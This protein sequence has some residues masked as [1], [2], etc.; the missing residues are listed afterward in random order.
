MSTA[1]DQVVE[2]NILLSAAAV[3]QASFSI[4]LIIGPTVVSPIIQAFTS[5]AGMLTA[6]YDIGDPEYIYAQEMFEQGLNPLEFYVG[7]RT[8]AVAQ[9]DTF[10]VATLTTGH[11]YQFTLNGLVI[12]YT[13]TSE[14]TQQSV[15]TALLADIGTVYPT[16]PPVTGVVSGS[17]GTA[18][19]TLTSVIAGQT[20]S[21][22]AI[23]ASLTH[24][25]LTASNGIANDLAALIAVNN[26]WYGIVLCSN[27]DNDIEQLAAAVEPLTKIFIGTS[28]DGS[29]ATS[30][31][32]D[33]LSVLK[34]KSYKRTALIYSPASFNLG[35]DAGWMGGNLPAVPGSNN[36]AY[37]TVAGISADTIS[38]SAASN[39]IGDPVAQIA[40]KNGNI[41]QTVGG[42]NVMQMGQMVGGQYIDITI[43]LDWL[44]STIQNNIYAALVAA[45]NASSKVPYTDL[46]STA[47]QSQVKAAIDQGVTNGLIDGNS[48]ITISAPLVAS[49]SAL[50]RQNR[51]APTITFSCRLQGAF[52]AVIVNGTVTV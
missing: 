12:S 7:M 18:L 16:N 48:P 47:M 11:N 25:A 41:F 37:Y 50:Q 27:S 10:A 45:S 33:I 5:P 22:S 1:L 32:T 51:V 30:S 28:Q 14:D 42:V 39:I 38:S 9:V 21:Y 19:L 43:G 4:P 17:A 3:A 26:L 23:D 24:I 8:T 31:T 52:N 2:V 29:I 36:W 6:G 49:V 44:K 46:G 13:A 35:I 15:L 40:G 20:V 34:S